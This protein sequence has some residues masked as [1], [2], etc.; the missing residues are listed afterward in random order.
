MKK[1]ILVLALTLMFS[2][3]T[4][5]TSVEKSTSSESTAPTASAEPTQ[6]KAQ[7]AEEGYQRI[8][9]EEAKKMADSQS[10]VIVDVRTEVEYNQGHVANA[11]LIPNET[12]GS[13]MPELLPDKD[14][15]I[16]LYCRS[17][18]RSGQAAKKLLKLGYKTIYD[19]GPLTD[20]PGEIVK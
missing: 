4:D 5:Q 20:W 12:I 1:F 8:S 7:D 11:L 19:F 13:E 14:A 9:G 15:V 17:G 6:S 10:V 3:C 18:N 2:A 16:I